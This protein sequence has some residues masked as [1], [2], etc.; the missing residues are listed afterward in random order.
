MEKKEM[1]RKLISNTRFTAILLTV[2]ILTLLL[3]SGSAQALILKLIV[4]SEKIVEGGENITF[5][6]SI[7]SDREN[8][9]VINHLI[10]RLD[11]PRDYECK[12][13]KDGEKIIGCEGITIEAIENEDCS[14]GY[15]SDSYNYGY[16]GGY[17]YGQDLEFK[18]ILD[19]N[20]FSPGTYKTELISYGVE[21]TNAEGDDITILPGVKV[22]MDKCSIRAQN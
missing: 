17:G 16:C 5:E 14:Y 12:F 10:L 4:T 2:S 20:F 8:P 18:I 7:Q 15:D 6:V 11:G 19:T 21:K 13:K 1:L 9:E 22:E 3:I